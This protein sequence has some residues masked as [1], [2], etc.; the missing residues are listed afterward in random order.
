MRKRAH[1]HDWS[2]L[3]ANAGSCTVSIAAKWHLSNIM[4][5][6]SDI[7][8]SMT[9]EAVILS[10]KVQ[11]QDAHGVLWTVLVQQNASKLRETFL[12]GGPT[13]TTSQTACAMV[14]LL[15]PMHYIS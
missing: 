9:C 8:P 14:L 6:R 11:I 5:G 1:G 4:Q 2:P 7:P 3:F 13:L 10:A 12:E 15:K